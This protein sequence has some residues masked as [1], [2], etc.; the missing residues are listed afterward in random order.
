MEG[1]EEVDANFLPLIYDTLKSLDRGPTEVSLKVNELQKKLQQM[2]E[3]IEGLPGIDLS[4]EEQLRQ[5][6]VLRQ[7]L[8]IKTELLR[9]YKDTDRFDVLP[10]W[11]RTVVPDLKFLSSWLNSIVC[12]LL[13]LLYDKSVLRQ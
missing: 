1:V 3:Q 9:K 2:R 12:Q 11:R 8:V 6:E 10:S 5:M 4:R 13:Q 7:Q